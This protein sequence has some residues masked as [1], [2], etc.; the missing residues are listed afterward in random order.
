MDAFEESVV[1][2]LDVGA[3]G[4]PIERGIQIGGVRLRK[5]ESCS[6]NHEHHAFCT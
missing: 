3:L 6:Y 2:P 5:H 1:H 4:R